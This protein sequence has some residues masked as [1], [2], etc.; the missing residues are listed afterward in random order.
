MKISL[1][2]GFYYV[3]EFEA[4]HNHTL[5]QGIMA[6]YL[7]SQRKVT[8]AQIAKAEVANSVGITNKA[9]SYYKAFQ[10]HMIT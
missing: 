2:D 4:S 8:E 1:R 10:N 5:A 7:R 3:Y 9:T 6:K